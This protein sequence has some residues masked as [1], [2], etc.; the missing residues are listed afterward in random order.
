MG[1]RKKRSL[2]DRAQDEASAPFIKA[3]MR[4]REQKRSPAVVDLRHIVG[5][6]D[7]ENEDMLLGT[8]TIFSVPHHVEFYRVHDVDGI[9]TPTNDPFDRYEN[10][11]RCYEG[12]Y[13]TVRIPGYEGEW[14]AHVMPFA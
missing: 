9:Q 2:D 12:R 6:E 14:V 4:A 10:L 13:R 11:Q 1:K 8:M 7:A 3:G 5:L